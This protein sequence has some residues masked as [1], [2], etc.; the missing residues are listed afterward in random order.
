MAFS[1]YLPCTE[2]Q[3]LPITSLACYLAF[4]VAVC[5]APTWFYKKKAGLR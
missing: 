4:A 5:T 3:V 2:F 1:R